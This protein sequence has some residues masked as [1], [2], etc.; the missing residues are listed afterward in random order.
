MLQTLR[1][2]ILM[3]VG[4]F[5]VN[6]LLTPAVGGRK[7]I[8]RAQLSASLVGAIGGFT[9]ELMIRRLTQRPQKPF[10]RFSMSELLG[11]MTVAAVGL[12]IAT[13]VYFRSS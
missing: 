4:A 8:A 5:A 6:A 2:A 13:N 7:D 9:L 3:L 10:W 1:L 11:A 12:A